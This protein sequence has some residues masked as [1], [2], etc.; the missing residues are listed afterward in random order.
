MDGFQKS[1]KPISY[2]VKGVHIITRIKDEPFEVRYFIGFD[3]KIEARKVV[4]D[5]QR[6]C[7]H[8]PPL[9][10]LHV[11]YALWLCSMKS[12]LHVRN[13]AFQV[14]A[15]QLQAAVEAKGFKVVDTTILC[16]GAHKSK[17]FGFV[18]FE[19]PEYMQ[20]V[21]TGLPSLFIGGRDAY[22]SPAKV[23]Q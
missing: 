16:D 1:W 10:F 11:S 12:C 8:T 18:E 14:T 13:L 21:A 20:R 19:S 4:T 17:G 15:E 9:L 23:K 7:A 6:E 5:K 3:G 2:E 22:F